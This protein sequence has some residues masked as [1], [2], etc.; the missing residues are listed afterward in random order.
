MEPIL[1]NQE[2]SMEDFEPKKDVKILHDALSTFS[3]ID[4]NE[5][6]Q[7]VSKN[8]YGQRM[9]VNSEYEKLYQKVCFS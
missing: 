5:I 8:T 9:I 1:E 3:R 6:I 7:I 4:R 2:Y